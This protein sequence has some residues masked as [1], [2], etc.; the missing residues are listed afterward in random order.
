MNT[1]L[2]DNSPDS[3]YSI[4]SSP[5]GITS[6]YAVAPFWNWMPNSSTSKW[7]S[8]VQNGGSTGVPNGNYIYKTTFDLTGLNPSTA[9]IQGRLSSD[10]YVGSVLLNGVNTGITQTVSFQGWTNYSILNGFVSGV[11]TL[12]FVAD[13][14]YL[15]QGFRN[16]FTKAVAEPTSQNVPEPLTILGS[17]TAL[18]IGS[19]FKR[20][21][22]LQ[23]SK[24]F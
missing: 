10:D 16:E 14:G 2:P 5:L 4:T 18:A 1:V 17:A 19:F 20:K 12:E 23:T 24:S 21:R 11:N 7:I 6:T 8:P 22:K 3:H 9:E 15:L 13:N